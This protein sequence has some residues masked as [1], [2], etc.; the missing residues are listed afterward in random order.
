MENKLPSIN[1]NGK[2]RGRKALF[3][4]KEEQ[5]KRKLI[6]RIDS[7]SN[8]YSHQGFLFLIVIKIGFDIIFDK[9][10]SFAESFLPKKPRIKRIE[11]GGEVVFDM[12]REEQRVLEH[13]KASEGVTDIKRSLKAFMNIF[14]DNRLIELIEGFKCEYNMNFNPIV[15]K[16]KKLHFMIDRR[17][18]LQFEWMGE[19][20][21]TERDIHEIGELCQTVIKLTLHEQT[22]CLFNLQVW[23]TISTYVLDVCPFMLMNEES[24]EE[25]VEDDNLPIVIPPPPPEK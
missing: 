25:G 16:P 6:N 1:Q 3:I 17:K 13:L 14:V 9:I 11:F 21:F 8:D 12:E 15:R 23:N 20:A 18:I 5:R 19:N 10:G 24:Q 7:N 2:K 4:T 22:D